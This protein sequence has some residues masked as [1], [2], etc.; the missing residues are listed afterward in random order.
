MTSTQPT[1]T[2]AIKR[3]LI[4][5]THSDL[6]NL[7]N[8]DMEVQVNVAQDGG[9]RIDQ[10]FK[11]RQWHGWTDGI[12]I[13][14]SFRIP[15]KANSDPEYIDKEMR[16]N[17]SQHVEGIGCTGWDWVKRLSRWVAFDFDA[18]S[19]H[20]ENHIKRLTDI[21]LGEIRD[22]V[23]QI[24][25]VTVRRS[26]GGKGLHLYVFVNPVTTSNHTEH[27]ALARSIL[28]LM[29]A[30]SGFDFESKVDICGG[31][32][33]IWHKKMSPESKGLELIKQGDILKDI[34]ENWKEHVNVISGRK[35]KSIPS[36]IEESTNTDTER[37]FEELSGQRSDI[38][39]DD[40]HKRL[41]NFL[42]ETGANWWYDND[43]RM[44]VTH[45]YHLKEAHEALQL[46]GV[47]KTLAQGTEKGVDHNC[48]GFP[49]KHGAWAIRRYSPG[50]AEEN[51]W[52][53]DQNGW[54][55]CYYNRDADISTAA[56]TFNAVESKSGA[57]VFREAELAVKAASMLGV[58]LN[59]PTW[60]LNRETKIKEHRGNRLLIEIKHDP[61][62]PPE[63]MQGWL[64][65]RNV[66]TRIFYTP[67]Q[68]SLP[69]ES[70]IAGYDKTIRHIISE[71]G[72]D[73]GW[74][75]NTEKE[76][77]DEPLVNVKLH[78]DGM[79][80]DAKEVKQ[81]LGNSVSKPWTLVNRPFQEEYLGNRIWNRNSC[82]LRFKI[83]DNTIDLKYPTW[84][85]ILQHC[86]KGLNDAIKLSTWAKDNGI[87]TG[88][89]Y[90]KCWV[91]SLFQK[92]LEPLPYLFFYGNQNSGKSVFH[93]AL[94]LLITKGYQRADLALTS[95]SGFNGELEGALICVVEET[96]LGKNKTA[97]NRIKDWVTS[98]QLNI[99]HM[100]KSPYH[101]ANSTH[102]V[103]CANSS[104]FC[105]IFPGDSR[106]T[107]TYVEDID[108]KDMISKRDLIPLLEQE[109]SDFLTEIINLEIPKSNDRLNIPVMITN[110]K[111][112]EMKSN[113]TYLEIFL[114]ERCHHITGRMIKFSEFYDMFTEWLDP[115]YVSEWS[116]IKVGKELPPHYPKARLPQTGQFWIGNISWEA[117]KPEEP[118]LAKLVIDGAYLI[119]PEPEKINPKD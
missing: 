30:V 62:D 70:N 24:P 65:E 44:L 78:F 9:E 64:N 35:R 5:S 109:A 42:T 25:W 114:D 116:K 89:D 7:Y 39:L 108:E 101:V 61:N 37:L 38:P 105:P 17:L 100:Y 15:Y 47:F 73:Q 80:L 29:S 40:E 72:S 32:M 69:A 45:T 97:Y 3:F 92:P 67:K 48:F 10:D 91:A 20:S 28:G 36:F 23:S 104:S 22:K 74:M 52:D 1:K 6:A 84:I 57:Y 119:V 53:Q 75:I 110:E 41:I 103:Q 33:W 85:K 51:T 96:D 18:I 14:K 79:G 88:G 59:L 82:Q 86:G 55:R 113:R 93:E 77:R 21:Q 54:T 107:M 27:S 87:L 63:K 46:K 31:N 112:L 49:L 106:I 71:T 56:K 16:F 99:R 76:W 12:E 68:Q 11:G 95:N 26:T 8:H 94:S 83:N 2:E 60:A 115:S 111:I 58:E 90:L 118:E 50:V 19:G 66:W 13:W 81:I 117:R 98:R 4:N 43:H 34:P 102:W